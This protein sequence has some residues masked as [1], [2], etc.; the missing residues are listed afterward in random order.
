MEPLTAS[1]SS[2]SD[3]CGSDAATP[4]T[5][6]SSS[7][8]ESPERKAD[9]VVTRHTRSDT[10]TAVPSTP[11]VK[12]I[13][14][15][16]AGFVGGPTAA[17]IAYH[18]PHITVNVVDLNAQRIAAWNSNHLPIHENGLPKIV[19]IAR[20]GTKAT[21]VT[22]PAPESRNSIHILARKPNLFFSCNVN[23]CIS[24]ADIIFICVNT[25]TKMYGVGAGASADLCALEAATRTI[26]THAR[27]GAV[28]V[29]KST[30]P[31]GTATI[32]S[33]ILRQHRPDASFEVLSNPEF[34]AEGSAVANLTNPD[35]ILIGSQPNN[36]SG[37]QA[38]ASL[39]AI[40][41]SWIPTD[42]ILTVNTFSSE[43]AKLVANAML[44]QR[45]SSINAVSALCEEL[46][47]D[48]DEVSRAL[49]ADA[50]IGP[51]FL[52]AGVGFGGS[53]FEKDILNL[54]YLARCLHLDEVA[55][56]WT[57]VLAINKYQRERFASAVIG[58]LNGTLRG[59]K[60]AVFGFAFKDGTNDT[61]NSVAVHVIEKLVAELPREVAIFDP[62]CVPD[63]IKEEMK[64]AMEDK[65]E[66]ARMKVTNGWREAVDG[67][68][69]VCILTQWDQFRGPRA[70]AI[71]SKNHT[72]LIPHN[73]N[74]FSSLFCEASSKEYSEVDISVLEQEVANSRAAGTAHSDDP[75]ERLLPLDACKSGCPH[76][77]RTLELS[78]NDDFVDWEAVSAMMEDHSWIFDGRNVVDG[79]Y[80]RSLGF[81]VHS[82]GKGL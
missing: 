69:A 8:V 50:R 17:L 79:Q 31:C 19:R 25:P 68:S 77:Q 63:E 16:G 81:Q 1:S 57:S 26:A 4:A 13:C 64:R 56:Y 9:D 54:A 71:A 47:A 3:K 74:Y 78:G 72:A 43:L 67:A 76:C 33:N 15:V 51:R 45:I 34:L 5:S 65:S 37:R 82:I 55:E 27:D 75:L 10:V 61:R 20:D 42:R 60:V 59:K 80:L 22:L 39:Q 48:V 35:R 58:R 2:A 14:F 44:A 52:H 70:S 30:V 40:Y 11:S 21:T 41:A 12:S 36:P 24:E 38:A 7:R 46:G 49:G 18:N 32:I 29:E 66:T 62:G 6:S 23:T 73:D 53:C 28:V